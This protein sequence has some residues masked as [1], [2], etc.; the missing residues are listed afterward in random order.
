MAVAVV[1]RIARRRFALDRLGTGARESGGRWNHRGTAVIYAGAS[2]AIAALER[3]VHVAGTV[4]RDLVLV[5]IELPRACSVERPAVA[6][7]PKGWNLVPAGRSSMDF[8]TQWARDRRSLVLYVPSA[9]VHEE[10]NAVL[11]PA[12]PE[13]PPVK[14]TIERDF[15]YDAR[16]YHPRTS[17]GR[18]SQ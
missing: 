14:M 16:M 5:R 11:N 7:L 9:L 4:P 1:W 18:R 10:E 15:Q 3:F 12:H 8:G 2:V 17:P 13:F 6:S